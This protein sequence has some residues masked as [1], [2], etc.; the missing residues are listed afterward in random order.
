MRAHHPVSCYLTRVI[1]LPE[2]R[3][4]VI[5]EDDNDSAPRESDP[6][7]MVNPRIHSPLPEPPPL[8]VETR[9]LPQILRAQEAEGRV[10][11]GNKATR[12]RPLHSKPRAK[13]FRPSSRRGK[14]RI[15]NLVNLHL[16]FG[17]EPL[18]KADLGTLSDALR[19]VG[20]DVEA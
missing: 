9:L 14:R 8:P 13:L 16:P 11:H 15:A 3:R 7:P 20:V 5:V 18:P 12:K 4:I 17:Y 1:A 6:P 19:K 2:P 10:T